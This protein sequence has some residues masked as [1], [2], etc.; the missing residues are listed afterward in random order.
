M[1]KGKLRYRIEAHE[2]ETADGV[3]S[4]SRYE[5]YVSKYIYNISYFMCM[6]DGIKTLKKVSSGTDLLVLYM[7]AGMMEF[8]TGVVVLNMS[9]RK[10]IIDELGIKKQALSR[11]FKNLREAGIIAYHQIV[12]ED[13]GEVFESR[14]E[15]VLNT[16][17][18]WR[19]DLSKRKSVVST[20][21]KQEKTKKK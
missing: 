2:T 20:S 13:T 8:D 4:R 15:F 18:F 16:G 19:G 21:T 9:R 1:A 5:D 3:K 7:L 11:S 14:D 12:N 6:T 17:V 10:A